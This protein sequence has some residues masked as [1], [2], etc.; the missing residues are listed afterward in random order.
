VA[1]IIG[2]AW[3]GGPM[4]I[5][6]QTLPGV[7]GGRATTSGQNLAEYY[8]EVTERLTEL[9][10]AWRSAWAGDRLDELAELYHEEGVLTLPGSDPLWTREGIRQG[11][12]GLLP[13]SGEIQASV[14]DFDASGR[15]AYVW[16]AFSLQILEPDGRTRTVEGSHITVCMRMGRTWVIR[17]QTLIPRN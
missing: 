7:P 15:M 8:G 3:L 10:S 17:S 2:L 6:A 12:E 4:A 14:L 13:I 16:G 5:G 11:L 9:F 1:L